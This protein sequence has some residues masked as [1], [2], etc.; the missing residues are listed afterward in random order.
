FLNNFS[1]NFEII[2]FL[3]DKGVLRSY[4][5]CDTCSRMLHEVKYKRNKDGYAF[6]CNFSKCEAYQKYVSIRKHSF[7]D[8]FSV[9]LKKLILIIY[10]WFKGENINQVVKDFNLSK[11]TISK[12][13]AKLR[14]K[15]NL[16]FEKKRL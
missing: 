6:K 13:Y 11:D 2:S 14:E 12:V 10:S 15:A 5:Y 4:L 8:Y 3:R 9:E 16:Y 7:F 1:E